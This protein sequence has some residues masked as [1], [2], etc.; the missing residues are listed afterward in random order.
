MLLPAQFNLAQQIKGR[1]QEFCNIILSEDNYG[2][3]VKKG[4]AQLKARLEKA[5]DD[6]IAD[7]TYEKIYNKWFGAMMKK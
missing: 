6:V 3:A 7:G 5:L 4:N 2:F 1:G